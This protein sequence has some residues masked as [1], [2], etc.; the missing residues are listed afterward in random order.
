MV[1]MI[2]LDT[3]AVDKAD[4]HMWADEEEFRWAFSNFC[5]LLASAP[6]WGCEGHF[7]IDLVTRPLWGRRNAWP[8][9]LPLWGG[10]RISFT[11]PGVFRCGI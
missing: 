1:G 5:Q 4:C 9:F 6:G 10:F 3:V 8:W 7:R 11:L 2:E